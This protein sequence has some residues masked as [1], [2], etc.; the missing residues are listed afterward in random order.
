MTQRT[1]VLNI[2]ALSGAVLA[3]TRRLR[4][5]AEAGTCTRLEPAL[6]P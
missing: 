3:R 6:P 1:V 5:L 4:A 2:V